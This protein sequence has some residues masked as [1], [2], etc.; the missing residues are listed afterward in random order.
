MKPFPGSIPAETLHCT[1][2]L[3]TILFRLSLVVKKKNNS[4]GEGD[5]GIWGPA[6]LTSAS[7]F[8]LC[9][10]VSHPL[11]SLLSWLRGQT[12]D[13]LLVPLLMIYS[14]KA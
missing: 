1:E 3:G 5:N 4:A 11:P 13:M 2:P 7:P 14:Y 6:S 12:P 9:T 8:F 10:R